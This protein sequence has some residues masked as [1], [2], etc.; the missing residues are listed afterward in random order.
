MI[1]IWKTI[2]GHPNYEVNRIGEVRNRKT[3]RIL[4]Q[5]PNRPNGY[6]RV[7]M[8][9]KHYYIH[10]IVA[11]TFYDGDHQDMDVSH[12]DG[13]KQN[14]TL[15]NLKWTPR[16]GN[17]NNAFTDDLEYPNGDDFGYE[18]ETPDELYYEDEER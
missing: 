12:I 14:N 6:I 13:N 11:D 5:S 1:E 18:E 3:G 2:R 16:R 7:K 9:N 17:D 4:S 8:D 15:L 10:R